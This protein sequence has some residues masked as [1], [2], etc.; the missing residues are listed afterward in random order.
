MALDLQCKILVDEIMEFILTNSC[1]NIS[2]SWVLSLFSS[3]SFEIVTSACDEVHNIWLLP[4]LSNEE[5]DINFCLEIYRTYSF[6]PK[7]RVQFPFWE[8]PK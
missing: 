7:L 6:H 5:T 2:L 3:V 8:I 1:C 4:L